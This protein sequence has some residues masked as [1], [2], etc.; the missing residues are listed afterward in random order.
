MQYCELDKRIEELKKLKHKRLRRPFF[1]EVSGTPKSGKTAHINFIKTLFKLNGFK[2]THFYESAETNPI[3]DKISPDFN[4][5]SLF[6]TLGK[7]LESSEDTCADIVIFERGIFDCLFWFNWFKELGKLSAKDFE[8]Y[9]KLIR[10][11]KWMKML[12]LV[13]VFTVDPD[14]ALD[15][16]H[17]VHFT[18]KTGRIM[19]TTV[20]TQFNAMVKAVSRSYKDEFRNVQCFDTSNSIEKKSYENVTNCIIDS[21]K[22]MLDENVGY[23]RKSLFKKTTIENQ[24]YNVNKRKMVFGV[25]SEV[26]INEKFIQPIVIGVITNK[27]RN[28]VLILKKSDNAT[29]DES[30]ERG[31]CLLYAGG[32]VR[33]EDTVE[34]KSIRHV[35]CSTLSREIKEELGISVVVDE[36]TENHIILANQDLDQIKHF[37]ICYII[38][39]DDFLIDNLK[40]T[41]NDEFI[42]DDLSGKIINKEDIRIEDYESWSQYIYKHCIRG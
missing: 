32:H 34:D 33:E 35:F 6:D 5:L 27:S 38:E 10:Y 25:K 26:E 37:A 24:L 11:K 12:D 22:Y 42:K 23:F 20:L 17:T 1:I 9:E 19:N 13:L 31:K 14:V 4:L 16:E 7:L 15:R 8:F 36:N 18:N 41:L 29:D 2:V 30:P 28:K 39:L 40:L 3:K 21:F